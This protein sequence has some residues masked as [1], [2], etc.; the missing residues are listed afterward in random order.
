MEPFLLPSFISHKPGHLATA[1][2][3]SRM[4][5]SQCRQRTW[6]AA[7]TLQGNRKGTITQNKVGWNVAGA[8]ERMRKKDEVIGMTPIPTGH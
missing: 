5:V 8:L 2:A 3:V 7:H 1:K 6:T 4:K